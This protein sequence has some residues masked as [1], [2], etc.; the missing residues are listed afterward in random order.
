MKLGIIPI[1]KWFDLLLQIGYIMNKII[2]FL[3]PMRDKCKNCIR[4]NSY[5]RFFI[6]K[7]QFWIFCAT[8]FQKRRKVVPMTVNIVT[9]IEWAPKKY[10]TNLE[11]KETAKIPTKIQIKKI[12]H[13]IVTSALINSHISG[14]ENTASSGISYYLRIINWFW[15]CK[16]KIWNF[17]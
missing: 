8:P 16:W 14:E 15:V 3:V 10:K 17:V 5:E 6:D 12:A 9:N 11:T 1:G 4:V 13:D 7:N 2:Y